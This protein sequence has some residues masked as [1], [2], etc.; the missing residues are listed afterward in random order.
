MTSKLIL[1]TCSN[2]AS[3][4]RAVIDSEQ[5]TDV[6]PVFFPPNC[7]NTLQS[8]DV[9]ADLVDPVFEEGDQVYLMGGHC[10]L[11][12]ETGAE[13]FSHY[14]LRQEP[15]LCQHWY[16]NPQ[17]LEQKTREGAYVM[18][19]GWLS[20]WP[21]RLEE[22]GLDQAT[23]RELFSETSKV[24]L[25]LDTG[26]IPNSRQRLVELSTYLDLPHA[27][28]PVGLDYFRLFVL[29]I[30]LTWRNDCS[31]ALA[32][33]A[34]RRS[35]DHAMVL[36]MLRHLAAERNES[37]V[38]DGL[39]D[40]FRSL[41]APSALHYLVIRGGEAGA[42]RSQTAQGKSASIRQR[43]EDMREDVSWDADSGA[44]GVRFSQRNEDL[45]ALLIE[46]LACPEHG[47][48]YLELVKTI[49]GAC[50]LALA[51]ARAYQRLQIAHEETRRHAVD[52]SRS[53]EELE[54]FAYVASHDLREPLRMIASYT[55]LLADDYGGQLDE[56]AD[57]FIGYAQ[58]GAKRMQALIDDLLTL[59]RVGSRGREL[60]ATDCTELVA[61]VVESLGKMVADS[62]AEVVFGDLPI[63][64]ADRALLAQVFQNLI[65]NGMK[66]R[67]D[68]PPRVEISAKRVDADWEITVADN[69]IGIDPRFHERI[70]VIFQRLSARGE[71]EGTGIGLSIVKKIVEHH[72]GHVRVE[73][74]AGQGARFIFTLAAGDKGNNDA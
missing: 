53:N 10:M 57:M 51:N 62:Q 56:T 2:H 46:D 69:G 74:A 12:L 26:T 18:T 47:P 41:F 1:V 42:L 48:D 24:L 31:R 61:E 13:R 15:K 30:V 40:L 27:T 39:V 5:L 64:M 71:Y 16:A 59:S 38:V 17:L 63:V 9:L 67:G 35:A 65:M 19:P 55:Q 28:L 37:V 44:L 21:R 25:L 58:D 33:Q 11:G 14:E 34:N 52:L 45:G 43:L 22:L 4:L 72:G 49:R 68:E 6:Q 23:A 50:G 3:D 29:Q 73:S 20:N 70:F 54:Q 66:F 60:S 36:D 32:R 7:A 8:L